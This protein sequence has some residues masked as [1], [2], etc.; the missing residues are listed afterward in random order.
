M[1]DTDRSL[2]NL[3]AVLLTS[4]SNVIKLVSIE[5]YLPVLDDDPLLFCRIFDL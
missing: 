3:G 4:F 5:D 1:M 2:I